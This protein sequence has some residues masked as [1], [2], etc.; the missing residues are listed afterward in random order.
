MAFSNE[1]MELMIDESEIWKGWSGFRMDL[2]FDSDDDTG[3]ELNIQFDHTEYKG[4]GQVEFKVL[5]QDL[6]DNITDEEDGQAV[7]Y[8]NSVLPLL[9][10]LQAYVNECSDMIKDA[11]EVAKNS[12]D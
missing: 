4:E 9:E 1:D 7:D 5:L 11:I 6:L 10:S 2:D 12:M 8:E 3:S